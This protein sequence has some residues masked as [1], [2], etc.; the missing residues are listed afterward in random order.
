[1]KKTISIISTIIALFTAYS[2]RQQDDEINQEQTQR[3][4]LSNK[5]ISSK[6]VDSIKTLSTYE[7]I[8]EG[9]IIPDGDP[10]PKNG[11]QWKIS[12]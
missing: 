1:M 3:D 9:T 10:P 7:E 11:G 2:C 4:M 8:G 5:S 6:E 12:N